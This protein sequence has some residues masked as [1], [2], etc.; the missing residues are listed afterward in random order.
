VLVFTTPER[1]NGRVYNNDVV[2]WLFLVPN[3]EIHQI[4]MKPKHSKYDHPP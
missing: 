4:N 2:D 3:I 1:L